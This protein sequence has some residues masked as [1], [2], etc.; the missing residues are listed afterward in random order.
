MPQMKTRKATQVTLFF[1]VYI[2]VRN[3]LNG[4]VKQVKLSIIDLFNEKEIL[5]K[6]IFGLQSTDKIVYYRI[7]HKIATDNR[8]H[9]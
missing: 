6:K 8:Q 7:L 9:N 4:Q 5:N 1:K 2:N 3:K